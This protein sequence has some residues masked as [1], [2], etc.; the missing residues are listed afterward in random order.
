MAREPLRTK[1]ETLSLRLDSKTKFMLEFAARAKGQSITSFIETAIHNAADQIDVSPSQHEIKGWRTY[2]DPNE[3]IR[4]IK[5]IGDGDN[6]TS[7]EEDELL[8]FME[9]HKQF[10]WSDD[11]RQFPKKHYIT[12]LWP[13]IEDYFNTWKNTQST[14]YWAAG[15]AMAQALESAGVAAPSWPPEVRNS[16]PVK[17]PPKPP[18]KPA[19]SDVDDD[20]PF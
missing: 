1:S 12:I 10:F 2:W 13:K 9:A 7:A 20:V 6:K 18:A 16:P 5:M 4:T 14:S 15:K 3:G 8:S 17:P 11:R 19:A